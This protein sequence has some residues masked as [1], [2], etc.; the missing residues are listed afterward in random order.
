MDPV[1]SLRLAHGIPLRLDNVCPGRGRQVQSYSAASNRSKQ[2]GDPG[3]I[4][5]YTE[6]SIAAGSG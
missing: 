4:P 1:E 5:K 6:D 3:V 2:H